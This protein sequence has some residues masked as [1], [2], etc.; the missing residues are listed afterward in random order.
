MAESSSGTTGVATD[1]D[2]VRAT[3]GS[4]RQTTTW[5]YREKRSMFGMKT[6]RGWTCTRCGTT[7]EGK[8][9]AE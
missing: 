1:G 2:N 4:C 9:A 6:S 7:Q 3:C 5:V 8:P